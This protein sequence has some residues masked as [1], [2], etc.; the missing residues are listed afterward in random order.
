MQ[1]WM[2]VL[3]LGATGATFAAGETRAEIDAWLAQAPATLPA[4]GSVVTQ[5]DLESVRAL[6][7]PG[8]Y[9]YVNFPGVALEIEATTDIQPHTSYLEATAQHGNSAKLRA[10]GG[11]EGYVAGR[12]FDPAQFDDVSPAEAGM[13]IAWNHVHRWQY[14]GY[15]L[16]TLDMTYIQP[17]SDGRA[18]TL[19][20][21]MEGGGHAERRLV[22]EYH[23]VYLNHLAMLPGK[24][25]RVDASNS[26]KRYFKDYVTF[27]EPFDVAGT[28]FVIERALAPDE[29][30]QVNSYL[31]SQRRV[32]RLSAEER[33]D[34]FMGSNFTLD[35]FEGFSG[36]VMDYEWTY[37]GQKQ[38][39][40][41]A[42]SKYPELRFFGAQSNVTHDRWQVRP[43]FVVELKPRWSGH[44]MSAKI[45]LIDQQT[46]TPAM[47]LI[48]NRDGK[49]WRMVMPH[50]QI[51]EPDTST[52]ERALETSV[53]G[54]RGS[55]GLDFLANTTTLARATSPTEFP[56]MTEK[57]IDRRFALSTLTEGR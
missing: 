24:G 57:Q 53:P 27:V 1:V 7:A 49:L 29:E 44:P 34:S 19:E 41:V 12:P 54:W 17:T 6:I 37:L 20:A 2:G 9:D 32:R 51:P 48:L 30:D 55:I 43:T 26:D 4:P 5:A 13:M 3:A 46:Y 31:P 47:A 8:Y 23:R 38:V 15:K 18:G 28:T 39:L 50:Y 21:G 11:M 40:H 42:N 45:L 10:E 25:Y 56:T 52:A 16:D 22:Q 33:A 36:R 14:F 35:D